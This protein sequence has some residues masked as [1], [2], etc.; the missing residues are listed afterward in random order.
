M[1]L[2]RESSGTAQLG[3]PAPG[4]YLLSRLLLLRPGMMVLNHIH[5]RSRHHRGRNS[6]HKNAVGSFD[7][8][9]HVPL[10]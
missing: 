3:V 8:A 5:D 9:K 7:L 2:S 6:E 10:L 4:V 1:H